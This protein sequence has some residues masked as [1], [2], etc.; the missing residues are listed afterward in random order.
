MSAS[1]FLEIH[2]SPD[3]ALE[4]EHQREC[5]HYMD[6]YAAYK[7][8]AL[9]AERDA[10]QQEVQDVLRPLMEACDRCWTSESSREIA[11]IAANAIHWRGKRA[12]TAERELAT[13]RET[14]AA[15]EQSG[16]GWIPISE[17]LPEKNERVLA[18]GSNACA[19][20]TYCSEATYDHECRAWRP[21]I[22]MIVSHWRLL[23]TPPSHIPSHIP[24]RKPSEFDAELAAERVTVRGPYPDLEGSA[25]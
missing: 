23:P 20:K 16:D 15:L 11:T 9:T 1:E 22:W 21:A 17:R 3:S 13:A 25:K 2:L 10:L 14:I 12:E 4:P 18:F 24:P 5:E 7:T 8:T 19:T 6:D